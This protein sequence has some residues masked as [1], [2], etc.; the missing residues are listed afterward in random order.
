[1]QKE[2]NFKTFM[3]KILELLTPEKKNVVQERRSK[4]RILYGSEV[5]IID[6][7]I[8]RPTEY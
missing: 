7:V 5:K 2:G 8:T 1:M 3:I 4:H 6:T